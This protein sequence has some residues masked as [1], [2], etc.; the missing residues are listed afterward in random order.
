M[1]EKQWCFGGI[2]RE[3]SKCFVVPVQQQNAATLLSQYVVPG[4]TMVSDQWAA[5]SIIKGM[6]EGY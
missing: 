6:P 2:E 4:T 1:V 3:T 5:Y